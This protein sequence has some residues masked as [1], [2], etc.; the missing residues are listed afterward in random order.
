L[1]NRTIFNLILILVI[2]FQSCASFDKELINPNPLNKDKLSEL[3]GRYGIVHNKFD[4]IL[5]YKEENYNRQIWNSNNFLTEIDRK[6]IKDTLEIDTLKTYAFDL[7][8]LSPKRIK[9][10]YIENGKVFRKR[11]LKTKLKRDGYLYL[12]NKNTQ[13]MLVPFLA[14]AI[15][16][17]KTRLTKSDSGILIFDVAHFRYGA[18]L[19]IIGDTRTW[20]YRQEYERIE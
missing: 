12:R 4:S 17:K 15:D 6:L 16:I 7:K 10:E 5:I 9:I 19:I 2:L 3:D 1:R 20:K 13:F 11:I 14:G 8:V 18:A